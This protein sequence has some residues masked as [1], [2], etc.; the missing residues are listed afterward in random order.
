[1]RL[2]RWAECATVHVCECV[3][4]CV[5]VACLPC[6]VQLRT[7]F[8]LP[9]PPRRCRFSLRASISSF[10]LCLFYDKL[11]LATTDANASTISTP[12]PLPHTPCRLPHHH[13]LSQGFQIQAEVGVGFGIA[14]RM[15]AYEHALPLLLLLLLLFQL[16]AIKRRPTI[17]HTPLELMLHPL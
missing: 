5:C 1:M 6:C 2:I 10:Y 13:P 16:V 14:V 17:A 8:D 7:N 9:H 12:H 3:C 15:C 4:V 11:H